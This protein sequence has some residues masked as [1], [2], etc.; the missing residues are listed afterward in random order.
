MFKENILIFQ[1]KKSILPL[2]IMKKEI[3]IKQQ[4]FYILLK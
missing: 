4:Q 1:L 3:K 2:K